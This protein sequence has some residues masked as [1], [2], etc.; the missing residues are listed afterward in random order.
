VRLFAYGSL[1]W[2]PGFGPRSRTPAL[3]RGWRRSWCVTSTVH[4]GTAERPGVVLGLVPGGL[5]VG[6]VLEVDGSEA[7]SVKA[8]LVG[9]E[10]CETGYRPE[11]LDVETDAGTVRALCFLSRAADRAEGEV[12]SAILGSGGSS[13]TNLEYA[14]RTIAALAALDLG[15]GWPPACPGLSPAACRE[16]ERQFGPNAPSSAE[17]D[18]GTMN[19]TFLATSASAVAAF[20]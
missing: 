14:A 16:I 19:R 3:A 20:P 2:N 18:A 1:L 7:A 10:L 9:R 15:P 4:R 11:E 5:C 12:L 6:E 8:Y 13:G 17:S